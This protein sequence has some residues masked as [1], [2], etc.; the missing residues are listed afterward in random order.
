MTQLPMFQP[1]AGWSPPAMSSLPS[2][3]GASRVGI[4]VETRDPGLR[5]YG[6]GV[7]RGAQIIGVS[8]AIEDGPQHY[9]P[10]RH[11][12]DNLPVDSVFAYLREQAAC[13]KGTLVG[14]NMSYDLDF[15]AHE[16][17]VFRQVAWFRDVQVADPLI[18]E[19]HDSYS[20]EAIGERWGIPAKDE[21][22]LRIGGEAWGIDP[23]REMWKLPARYVGQYAATDAWAPL[24]ILRRQERVIEEQDLHQVYDLESR[25]LPVTVKMRRRGVRVDFEHLRRVEDWSYEQEREC[26][27]KV[28]DETGVRIKVGDVWKPEALARALEHIGVSVPKTKK[29]GKPSIEKDM[30]ASIKH[31]VARMLERARKVNK[32]RTTFAESVRAH[33]VNG[34][35][36][37]TFNQLR[38]TRDEDDDSKGGRF[39]R[40]SCTDPNL[41]QQPSRDD[42]AEF[43]RQVYVPDEGGIWAACDY[44]QQEPRM[45][46]H[47]AE[48]AKCRGAKA[49]GDRYR[50]D[51]LTDNHT[52]MAR[53]I[54]GYPDDEEPSKKHRTE[55]KIIFLGLCYGMGGA[56]LAR[57]L[58]LPTR[59]TRM[60]SG[61][62]VE[63]AGPEAQ[64]ILDQFDRRAPF[65]R[66]MAKKCEERAKS[67][68]YIVTL[69]GRRCR[70]PLREDGQGYDWT[71]K[72]LNRLIQGSS[73]DQTKAAMVALDNAGFKIQLQ[74]HDEIDLTVYSRQEGEAVGAIMRTCVP[75]TVPSRVDVEMGASWGEAK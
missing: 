9:L 35:I 19:L 52:M 68:G 53:I 71:H 43:W 67:R 61:K 46:V 8:F 54:H 7:R 50:A 36:H 65:V 49:A 45:L 12:E 63:V 16:G 20:N 27:Q 1:A 25:V 47:F 48:L 72:A 18:N 37:C 3:A 69:L 73:A 14:G 11:T 15:L 58:G 74:I 62:M 38:T 23:K 44:S 29:T 40:M 24:A 5:K 21:T 64:S 30:L 42:F 75:L 31:P 34:R 33:A 70:F 26:L 59:W 56:K 32:L 55:A 10:I 22:L 66:S 13:F 2:W 60:R 4:D 41:Q 39:G 57:S 28:Y 17:V 51:P 6:P